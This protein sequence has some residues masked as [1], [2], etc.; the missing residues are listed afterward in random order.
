MNSF[1]GRRTRSEAASFYMR[2]AVAVSFA[3]ARTRLRFAAMDG[4]NTYLVLDIETIPDRELHTP[5]EPVAGMERPF[6]PLYACRPIVLGVMWLD[7]DLG[8]KRIGTFGENK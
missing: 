2:I 4:D 5:P 7:A 8:C 3:A 6:P 1:L